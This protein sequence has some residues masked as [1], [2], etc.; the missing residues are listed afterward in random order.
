[1]EN[2]MAKEM[3]ILQRDKEGNLRPNKGIAR[4]Q[5][6]MIDQRENEIQKAYYKDTRAKE[7]RRQKGANNDI[8]E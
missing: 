6:I 2:S 7:L 4:A 5:K 3:Q 1:M 8:Q